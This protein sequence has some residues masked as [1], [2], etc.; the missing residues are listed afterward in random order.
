MR[1]KKGIAAASA[2]VL[3]AAGTA[4]AM[5]RSKPDALPFY[6]GADRTPRWIAPGSAE[7]A[8]IPRVQPFALTDQ[9][10]RTVTNADVAGKVYVASFF[11]TRC[12]QLCP[13]L[14]DGLYRVQQAFRN[15]PGV[16]ILSHS[17]TP[18]TDDVSALA[19]WARTHSACAGTWHLL[20]GGRAQIRRLAERSYFVELSDTTGNTDGALLHTETLILVDGHGRVRGMYDGT[21]PL[22]VRQLIADIRWLRTHPDEA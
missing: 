1:R 3:L 11:F 20:T 6:T 14:G 12:R 9:A 5:T 13:T 10:G 8:R 2:L 4:A 21:L 22:D 17:V 19:R 16:Q 15:D 18:E 7:Y